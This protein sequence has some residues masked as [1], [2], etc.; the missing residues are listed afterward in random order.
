V[1][2][3]TPASESKAAVR[4]G[5]SPLRLAIIVSHPI[6]YY[7]P[8][9]RS[10]A[11]RPDLVVRVFFTC[12][13]GSELAWDEGFK[14]HIGWDI[15]LTSGYEFENVPNAARRPS[16]S[17]FWGVRNPSLVSRVLAWSPDAV[18]LTGYSLASHLAALRELSTRSIPV[19]FRGDSHLLTPAPA[20]K[21]G[22][23][24]L[25]LSR[26]FRYPRAFLYVGQ[27]NRAYFESFGVPQ[28]KLF[29]C[30]H[31]IESE[32]FLEPAE[33]MEAE[34]RRWRQSLGIADDQLVLLFAG[35]FEAKKEP[36]GL[37]R[38]VAEMPSGQFVLV[39][40]GDGELADQVRDLA[41]R[42]PQRFRV[43]PFQNQRKMPV[44]HRLADLF[45]LPS[46]R[47]ETWGLAVNEA[48]AC[49]RPAL[50]SDQVGCA[51]D[52]II[53]GRTGDVFRSGDWDDFRDKLRRLMANPSALKALGTAAREWA[54]KF[55]ISATESGL[56]EAL[57]AVG[58]AVD[59]RCQG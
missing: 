54:G 45:V 35:K 52:L 11:S 10:L 43:L 42:D 17:H 23:K 33:E 21:R 9:Y 58:S 19:L 32:R 8:L 51:P 48:F 6:Q 28:S 16:T 1:T 27:H 13:D 3:G 47:W 15:P 14:Q 5:R 34:A 41:R 57:G 4:P 2:T 44:T 56:R 31:S 59:E 26:V 49:G 36:L 40:L 30:P 18:H 39:M 20:W 22:L 53:P 50:V 29:Y 7:V 55:T 37:M 25:L 24:R 12:H 38:A 46:S